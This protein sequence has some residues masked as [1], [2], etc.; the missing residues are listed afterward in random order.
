MEETK[1]KKQVEGTKEEPS[2]PLLDLAAPPL[3]SADVQWFVSASHVPN[4]KI[5][6]IETRELNYGFIITCHL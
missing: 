1:K 5:E 2:N 6:P 3:V 4:L